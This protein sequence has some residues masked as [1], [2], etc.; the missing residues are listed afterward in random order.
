M[1]TCGKA[2]SD[3]DERRFAQRT[4]KPDRCVPT[5]RFVR[6][7]NGD[8][9]R[10]GTHDTCGVLANADFRD[11]DRAGH[12]IRSLDC[13]PTALDRPERSDR[14]DTRLGSRRGH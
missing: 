7:D 1:E 11:C 8:F 12:K 6:N 5:F 14:G 13:D 3:L 10:R 2:V 9:L 4:L